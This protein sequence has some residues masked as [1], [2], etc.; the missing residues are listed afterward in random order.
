M[1]Y[2][3]SAGSAECYQCGYGY[4]TFETG[5]IACKS[6]LYSGSVLPVD[7]CKLITTVPSD[8]KGY[9]RS[10]VDS[11][12]RKMYRIDIRDIQMDYTVDV[13]IS[14]IRLTGQDIWVS[15]AIHPDKLGPGD[16]TTLYQPNNVNTDTIILL[17]TSNVGFVQ[18]NI[19]ICFLIFDE[20]EK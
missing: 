2:S 7:G 17:A 19:N 13:K 15:T 16:W 9:Y 12:V 5:S 6:C 14:I 4:Y 3:Y 18:V 11:L 1:T 10:A 8:K 20:R